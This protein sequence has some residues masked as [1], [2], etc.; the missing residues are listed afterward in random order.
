MRTLRACLLD[1][2]LPRLMAMADLWDAPLEATSQKDVA[3]SLAAHIL[4]ESNLARERDGLPADARDALEAL[5]GA[6]GK[7]PVA[8]FERRFG[9]I[10]P[11]GPGKLERERPW[12]T[13][14][15][16]AEVLWY[17][18]FISR[19]FDKGPG[20]PT[21]VIFVPSDMLAVLSAE[22][23]VPSEE[24]A[25]EQSPTQHSALGAQHSPL[26][27]DVVT[28]LCHI[29][30]SDVKLKANGEWEAAS[31]RALAPMMRDPDG[32]LDANL[33]RRF[34]FLIHIAQRLGWTR[35]AGARLKLIPQPVTHWL[36]QPAESQHDALYQ[37]WLNDETW[38]DLAHMAGLSLQMTHVWANNPLRERIAI[39]EAWREWR[40]EIGDSVSS[41]QSP[42]SSFAAHVKSTNP[43]FARP[44]GR[45]DT[46]HV[47]DE[48]TGAFL[49][50]FENWENVEGALIRH[51]VEKPLAWL[52]LDT[53]TVLRSPFLVPRIE[54]EGSG[55]RQDDQDVITPSPPHPVT[56][57]SDGRIT[58]AAWL[59]FERFQLARVAD[60]AETRDAAYV[61]RLTPSSLG[62]AK[63]Q[64]IRIARVIEFLEQASG[65]SIHGNLRSALT[66]WSERGVEARLEPMMIL[67]TQDAATMDALLRAQEVRRAMVDR[68][69]PNCISIRQRDAGAVRA[70][71]IES[72]LMV[73]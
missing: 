65:Q 42:I 35:I 41:L 55:K 23:P 29:Q 24:P 67:K 53:V 26:L 54:A 50:G 39:V 13:P 12:L 48:A 27:D 5:I 37:A 2:P 73:D 52:S 57:S 63:E 8:T 3:E 71:I 28:I 14:A 46:W 72:G 62:R 9:A 69:A 4:V 49:H 16:A 19:A 25:H 64:G 44:D 47:R 11:M 10:R 32:V 56:L 34:A 45:Y 17:R 7:T 60:W 31:R 6:G 15:N 18:G 36:Q 1:E 40:L 58:I 22:F 43:D 20:T 33:N 66:R 38:N 51:V 59:R 70:A 61:Y 21:E 68:F 30:N